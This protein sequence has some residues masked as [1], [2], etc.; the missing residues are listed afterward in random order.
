MPG[1]ELQVQA[2]GSLGPLP[3][4]CLVIPACNC[5][6]YAA[7]QDERVAAYATAAAPGKKTEAKAV[8]NKVGFHECGALAT[9]A[10]HA[11]GDRPS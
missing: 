2:V 9:A 1:K 10:K 5:C 3:P 8:A 11:L 7:S 4:S 6:N